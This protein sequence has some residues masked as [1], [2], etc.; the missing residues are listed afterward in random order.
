M[1]QRKYQGFSL[2]ELLV[3]ISIIGVLSS[4]AVVSLNSARV[5]AR[6]ALRKADMTQ[7]RTA[8]M[9]YYDETERYPIC[10][11]TSWNPA[12]SDFGAAATQTFADCYKVTLGSLLT[13]GAKP[14]L[15]QMPKDPKNETNSPSTDSTYL[16]RYISS[17]N[18][19]EY[20]LV[21]RIEESTDL[22][23]IRGW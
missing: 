15:S 10:G 7:M 4:L 6:D 19:G 9:L 21:F 12:A 1:K 3:V 22:Q 23:V 5:K 2:I 17:S 20:A 14:Y 16:Y 13:A 8:I 18:G 11:A